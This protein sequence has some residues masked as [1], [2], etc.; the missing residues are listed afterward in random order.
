MKSASIR[1]AGCG[2][3]AVSASAFSRRSAVL[4]AGAGGGAG[5]STTF[6]TARPRSGAPSLCEKTSVHTLSHA[7]IR[8]HTVSRGHPGPQVKLS[9]V[10]DAVVEVNSAVVK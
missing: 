4:T 7:R 6:W 5:S 2:S 8:A 3:R 10:A 9:V 1:L